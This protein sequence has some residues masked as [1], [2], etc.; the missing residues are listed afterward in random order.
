VPGP[1]ARSQFGG[2]GRRRRS[3]P[4]VPTTPIA[5]DTP[6][7]RRRFAHCRR[8]FRSPVAAARDRLSSGIPR[9]ANERQPLSGASPAAAVS[10]R[11]V[12][13][14]TRGRTGHVRRRPARASPLPLLNGADRGGSAAASPHRCEPTRPLP[15]R[16]ADDQAAPA[17][18]G[19]LVCVRAVGA[20]YVGSISVRGKR[21]AT[22]MSARCVA[23]FDRVDDALDLSPS[24]T[25]SSTPP[26][27]R[28]RRRRPF[29]LGDALRCQRAAAP[30]RGFTRRCASAHA[31]VP[32]A[33]G[34]IGRVR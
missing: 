4:V 30:V 25:Q 8:R 6:L 3:P 11:V 1:S 18:E 7:T 27:R 10:A 14:T 9:T 13:L 5:S 2:R 26:T 15:G 23:D 17:P 12:V 22:Q 19:C 34:R 31:V 29:G 20:G 21:T 24:T 32:T 33:R 16:S 28:R